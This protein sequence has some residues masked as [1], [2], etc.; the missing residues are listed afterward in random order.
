MRHYVVG[1]EKKENQMN[2]L[3]LVFV[4]GGIVF[5]LVIGTACFLLAGRN[6]KELEKRNRY[7]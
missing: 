4:G 7:Q 1:H 5:V 3:I 6:E 2:F